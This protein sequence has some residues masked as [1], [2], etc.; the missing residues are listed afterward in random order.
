[1]TRVEYWG[2]WA[3]VPVSLGGGWFLNW[4]LGG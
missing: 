3:L 4:V 2:L 1:M